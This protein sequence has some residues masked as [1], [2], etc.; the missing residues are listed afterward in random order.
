MTDPS[1]IIS[2]FVFLI[3]KNREVIDK[4]VDYWFTNHVLH[5]FPG[6]RNQI[7]LDCFPFL[8][9]DPADSSTEW[10]ALR[11]QK[12]TYMFSCRIGSSSNFFEGN[13]SCITDLATMIT[14]M[15]NNPRNLQFVVDNP[16]WEFYGKLKDKTTVLDSMCERV[17]FSSGQNGTL[18]IAEFDWRVD[19]IEPY[20]DSEFLT[21]DA[22][23]NPIVGDV[24]QP[25]A[26]EEI[27][28]PY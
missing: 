13:L 10:F 7:P 25:V 5:V 21:L 17:S 28:D 22:F 20:P 8:D 11:V 18:R 4:R 1:R 9:I 27:I 26:K 16:S 15:L 23:G 2:A 24:N 3:D 14:A 6:K 19:V 12:S